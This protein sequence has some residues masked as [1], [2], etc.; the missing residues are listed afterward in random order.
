MAERFFRQELE[1]QLSDERHRREAAQ[2]QVL[3][4]EYEL[5]GKE[6]ALQ[7]AERALEHKNAELQQAVMQSRF[8]IEGLSRAGSLSVY[9][10][11]DHRLKTLRSE[12]AERERQLEL[13]D[14]HISRLLNVLKQHKNSIFEGDQLSNSLLGLTMSRMA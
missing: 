8:S 4:L 14:Q 9:P 6:A 3:C 12:L 7:V 1:H 10:G 2:Q 13:K 11:E 5:D